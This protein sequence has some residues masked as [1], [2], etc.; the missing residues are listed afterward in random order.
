MIHVKRLQYGTS[1]VLNGPDV[2]S[3]HVL[4]PHPFRCFSRGTILQPG[5]RGSKSVWQPVSHG[6][7]RVCLSARLTLC[8][9]SPK[10]GD[11]RGCAMLTVLARTASTFDVEP[12]I[13]LCPYCHRPPG[14]W[15]AKDI[16]ARNL[17]VSPKWI[18]PTQSQSN[19]I[20]VL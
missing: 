15:R 8:W 2:T 13:A 4:Q 7:C 3:I 18:P 5:Q 19:L 17:D 9:Q 14:P 20:L 1:Q 10:D 16:Q 6:F 11:I 12:S